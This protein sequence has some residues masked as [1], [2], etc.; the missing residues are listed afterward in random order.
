MN[1]NVNLR[2][3]YLVTDS[4]V[5]DIISI[6]IPTRAPIAVIASLIDLVAT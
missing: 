4:K 6:S 5:Q 2:P 1:R 3:I